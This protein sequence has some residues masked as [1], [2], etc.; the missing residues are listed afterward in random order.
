MVSD[1]E[2]RREEERGAVYPCS[3]METGTKGSVRN[4]MERIRSP[5]A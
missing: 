2:E 4:L 5:S 1:K 3:G